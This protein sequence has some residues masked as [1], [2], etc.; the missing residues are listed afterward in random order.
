MIKFFGFWPLPPNHFYPDE[1]ILN[2]ERFIDDGTRSGLLEWVL[3]VS[4]S[5][6]RFAVTG[7][8]LCL[9]H[10]DET[11]ADL[12]AERTANENADIIDITL[13]VS[14]RSRFLYCECLNAIYFLIF[15]SCFTGRG[16]S[17]LHDFSELTIWSCGRFTYD[18][19][20]NAV[21]GGQFLRPPEQQL[22]RL[23]IALVENPKDHT[24][25]DLDIFRDAAHYWSI[26]YA[27]ELHPIAAVGAKIVS[28]HRLE[29]LQASVSLAWFE[30]ERWLIAHAMELGLDVYQRRRNGNV[31]NDE[32][33]S[34]K[35]KNV[36][37]LIDLFPE[38]TWL[39]ANKGGFHQVRNLR[40]QIAHRGYEPSH[41]ESARA[42][43]VFVS[44]FNFRSGLNLRIDTHRVP[45]HGVS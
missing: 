43:E 45:T 41:A 13:G 2:P 22:R 17:V 37:I 36:S 5:G 29:N 35:Y 33:G 10:L 7:D 27:L 6:W 18:D 44:M 8:L 15:C 1:L 28:E 9:L 19:D 24:P 32:A 38:G 31:L 40:N 20:G 26:V 16:Y 25:F 11:E 34:P 14:H 39:Y 4:G 23:R 42:L 12:N 30:I 3:D 21:R